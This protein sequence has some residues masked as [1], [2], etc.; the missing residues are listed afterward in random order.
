[1][2]KYTVSGLWQL[3]LLVG[4]SFVSIMIVMS[5]QGMV[6]GGV[7]TQGTM[8]WPIQPLVQ[9]VYSV[10][11]FLVPTVVWYYYRAV[12]ER[13][14]IEMGSAPWS[15][16]AWAVALPLVSLS[17][18]DALNTLNLYLPVAEWCWT[19]EERVNAQVQSMLYVDSFSHLFMNIF[20]GALCPAVCEE[21]FFRGALQR[22]FREML[23]RRHAAVWITALVFSLVHFQLLSSFARILL[24]AVLGY[25]YLYT[26][27]IWIPVVAHFVNNLI[28]VIWYYVAAVY[29]WPLSDFTPGMHTNWFLA[30]C[31]LGALV[32]ILMNIRRLSLRWG[33]IH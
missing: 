15:F 11:M 25:L 9:V 29:Q 28:V 23:G 18:V 22:V 3:A 14:P 32:L 5:L 16:F 1:M 31:S 33:L 4:T 7:G 19:L 13:R 10:A 27:T 20:V 21:F 30:V 24:G 2:P 17:C 8:D 6:V 12:R 26:R